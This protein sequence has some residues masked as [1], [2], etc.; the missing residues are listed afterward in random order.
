[1]DKLT[2]LKVGGAVVEEETSL[3]RL[4][5]NFAATEGLKILIHGGGRRA[6]RIAAQ[7]GIESRMVDGRRITDEN[8]LE[9]VTMVYG[10]LINK[11]VVAQ[12]Q[13]RQVDAIGLTGADA[14]IVLSHRRPVRNGIDYGCVGDIDKVNADRLSILLNSG[15]VPVVAPLSHDGRG[16]M[17]NINA[18]TMA[19]AVAKALAHHYET[20][21]I[22][23]FEKPGVLR[24]ADDDSSVIAKIT[25]ND[26]ERYLADGTISGGMKPKI[27][28]ALDA[29]ESGVE[30]VVITSAA[31][32]TA[33]SGTSITKE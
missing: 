20:T 2:I 24:N 32:P 30:R 21:L 17:L 3:Q 4:L 23:C 6:T 27:E 18:D 29:V 5:D 9:V 14:G 1:M 15:M 16:N 12:L 13:S 8:M 28:N 26:Y 22:Y 10:G 19:A 31:H 7:L 25:R 11:N 33:D